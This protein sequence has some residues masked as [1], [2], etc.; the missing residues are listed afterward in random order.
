MKRRTLLT[1]AALAPLA[2]ELLHRAT[3]PPAAPRPTTARGP[4]FP[5]VPLLTHENRTVRFYDDILRGKQVVINFIYTQCRDVCPQMTA[6][7]ARV[8]ECLGERVGRDIFMYSLSL[9]PAV[10]T[11]A[12]LREYAASFRVKPGWLFLTGSAGDL[13]TVRRRLGFVDPD[14]I[15][16]R[17]KESHAGVVLY[18][19]EPLQ[20]WAACP[21]MSRPEVVAE[22]ILWMDRH[23]RYALRDG[24]TRVLVG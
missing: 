16:D 1:G 11:P 21:A 2:Y 24:R 14:P 13:E 20:R 3:A 23:P 9:D 10:D 4:A 5:N 17:N 22:S 19:N 12:V 15:V 8:Q 18:G 7:L 6:N